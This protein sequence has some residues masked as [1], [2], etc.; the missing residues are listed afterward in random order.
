[1]V[2]TY[3]TEKGDEVANMVLYM[4]CLLLALY[5]YIFLCAIGKRDLFVSNQTVA[6]TIHNSN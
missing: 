1:M 5:S 2:D 3:H 6:C 4:M